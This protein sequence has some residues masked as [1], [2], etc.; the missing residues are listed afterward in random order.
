[1]SYTDSSS[2]KRFV[3][4]YF[5]KNDPAK[6]QRVVPS[7][8]KYWKES[9][10]KNYIGGPFSDRSGGIISFVAKNIEEATNIIMNDPFIAENILSDKW[11]KEWDVE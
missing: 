5:M 3:Y 6:I 1:M 8:I 10:L 2:E 11:I 7:H 4:F 9:N